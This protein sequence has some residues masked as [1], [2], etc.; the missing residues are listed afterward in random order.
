MVDRPVLFLVPAVPAYFGLEFVRV[1]R[2]LEV[3]VV[4][5]VL[6]SVFPSRVHRLNQHPRV[7]LQR[8]ADPHTA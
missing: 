5:V 7:A 3:E 8:L 2:C 6:A 4:V 1:S